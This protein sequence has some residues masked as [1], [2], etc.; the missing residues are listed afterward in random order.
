MPPPLAPGLR[1]PASTRPRSAPTAKATGAKG[2]AI[3]VASKAAGANATALGADSAA[4]GD[5][6]TAVGTAASAGGSSATAIGQRQLRELDGDRRQCRDHPRS[7]SSPLAPPA[8]TYTMAGVTS[9]ASRAAQSGPLQVVTDRQR[10]Q[11]LRATQGFIFNTLTTSRDRIDKQGR[12]LS[13]G[14]AMAMAVEDPDLMGNG[15]LRR[16]A[17]LG[18][19]RAEECGGLERRRGAGPMTSSARAIG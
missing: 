14:V 7:T 8:N 3:G 1:R 13:E 15:D 16:Q 2:T 12:K 6:A 4:E 10:R 19:L 9:D 17:Q 18:N 5:N 11:S